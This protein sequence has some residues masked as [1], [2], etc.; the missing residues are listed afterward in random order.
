MI[1]EENRSSSGGLSGRRPPGDSWFDLSEEERFPSWDCGRTEGQAD[2]EDQEGAG[3]NYQKQ[4]I[5]EFQTESELSGK[6]EAAG[7]NYQK[8][9][10]GVF[11]TVFALVIMAGGFVRSSIRQTVPVRVSPAPEQSAAVRESDSGT[12]PESDLVPGS[13]P[14]EKRF[15]TAAPPRS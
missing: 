4:R 5:G 8:Q 11:Q 13:F 7:H 14:P 3:H 2:Q 6:S 1:T 12:G 15:P 9:T 10:F